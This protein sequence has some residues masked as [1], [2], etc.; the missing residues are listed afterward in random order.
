MKKVQRVRHLDKL[1]ESQISFTRSLIRIH[2]QSNTRE[3]Y[4]DRFMH[5]N[6]GVHPRVNC[7]TTCLTE[8]VKKQSPSVFYRG[9]S[10]L[11]DEL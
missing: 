9:A 7:P 11:A 4:L 1:S 5:M 6:A 8:F 3:S 10:T 2:E